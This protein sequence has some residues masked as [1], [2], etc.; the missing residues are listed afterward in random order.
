MIFARFGVPYGLQDFKLVVDP[1]EMMLT[2]HSPSEY[3]RKK[4]GL[5]HEEQGASNKEK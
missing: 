4:V 5:V 3:I 2:T 1:L